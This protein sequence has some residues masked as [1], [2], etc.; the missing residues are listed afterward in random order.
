MVA[1]TEQSVAAL[2]QTVRRLLKGEINVP[3]A[4][5][6]VDEAAYLAAAERHRLVVFLALRENQLDWTPELGRRVRD[7]ARRERI[8]SL[9]MARALHEATDALTAA[10]VRVLSFKGLALAAQA[11]GDF[12]ARGSGDLDLFVHPSDVVCARRSLHNAGW[13]ADAAYASPGPTWAWSHTLRNYYELPLHSRTSTVDLHWHLGP[14]RQG[15]PSFDEAWEQRAIVR[16]GEAEIATLGAVDALRHSAA[17]AAKDDWALLRSLVDVWLLRE[18]LPE[19]IRLAKP[20]SVSATLR[21]VDGQ[22]GSGSASQPRNVDRASAMQALPRDVSIGK[23]P[24]HATLLAARRLSRDAST[25]DDLKRVLA[26]SLAH[27]SDLGEV[28]ATHLAGAAIEVARIRAGAAKRRARE[29][30]RA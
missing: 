12:A 24:G 18:R 3:T 2:R 25:I 16:V 11:H 13:R 5:P 15:L 27:P 7:S 14:T 9:G 17:H 4:T 6:E 19:K 23:F 8:A 29:W 21:I 20:R 30:R 26:V 10:G 1:Y 28:N 22:L